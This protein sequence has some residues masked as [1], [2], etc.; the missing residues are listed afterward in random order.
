MPRKTKKQ[1]RAAER[2]RDY[3]PPKP[4]IKTELDVSADPKKAVKKKK[5]NKEPLSGYDSKLA[6]FTFLDLRKTVFVSIF[7]F[8]LE[9]VIFYANIRG[10][11]LDYIRDF[12]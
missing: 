10:I 5:E 4:R 9:L 1:K 2:R 11:R 3:I 6:R 8:T 7:L 12:F